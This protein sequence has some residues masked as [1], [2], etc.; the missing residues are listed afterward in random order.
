M[1]ASKYENDDG[2]LS[3]GMMARTLSLG[4]C[5][6]AA[7]SCTSGS[8]PPPATDLTG[9]VLIYAGPTSVSGEPAINGQPQTH[10]TVRVWSAGKQVATTATDAAGHYS[11]R[12]QHGD[13]LVDACGGTR[14]SGD[15]VTID[16]VGTQVHD[17]K[18][19]GL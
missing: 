6:A 18:C 9:T 5:L 3:V 11:I 1:T 15:Q 2:R 7:T 10:Q 14:A 8:A 17:I 13:Y 4:L 12:L 19:F 16:S